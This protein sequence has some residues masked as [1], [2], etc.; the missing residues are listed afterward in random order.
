MKL[1]SDNDDV[2][3]RTDRTFILG[4][5]YYASNSISIYGNIQ[6]SKTTDEIDDVELSTLNGRT[7]LLGMKVRF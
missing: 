2:L 4:S 5:E 3:T 7:L 1:S 6:F